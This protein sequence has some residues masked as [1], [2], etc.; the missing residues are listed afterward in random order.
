MKK[1]NQGSSLEDLYLDLQS[2][3]A[4]S[5]NLE[6][7]TEV[8]RETLGISPTQTQKYLQ[9]EPTFTLH[10]PRQVR[11]PR[12]KTVVPPQ[13]DYTW[14]ADL[15][16]MRDPKLVAQNKRTR[17]LLTVIDVLSKYAWVVAMKSKKGKATAE[18]FQHLLENSGGR[19]PV[20]LQTD[21][22]KEFYNQHMKRLLDQ[23]DIHH[24][25]TRGEPKAAL[26]ERFNRTLKELMYKY[27]TARNTPKYLEA[28]PLLVNK[29]NTS[30]HSRTKMAPADVTDDNASVVWKRLYQP[31]P[32]LA[33]YKFRPGNFVRT[34][35]PVKGKKSAFAKSY[36]GN[37]SPDVYV[38]TDRQ[39]SLYDGVNYYK[40]ETWQ[41]DKVPGRFYEPQLQK[42]RA[43][44]NQWRVNKKLKY[45]GRGPTRQVLVN[46]QGVAP[47]YRTWIPVKELKKNGQT[48][49]EGR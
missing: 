47:D 23:Y 36:R 13:V 16:E 15:V 45:K 46:W 22:G 10:R 38:V 48:V 24:Y 6:E 33:S 3:Y 9:G 5:G 26:A 18:A 17:Y 29:Y 11:F 1:A 41:G 19:R 42:V 34:S 21:Q 28:L 14:Q 20:N 39:R 49:G 37:W 32:P 12:S 40:L 43:L 2:P 7:L 27:M 8:A 35:K 31:T 30:I 25:S 44:P 4:L